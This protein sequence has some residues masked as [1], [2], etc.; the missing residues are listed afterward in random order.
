MDVITEF[1]LVKGTLGVV[2]AAL[3]DGAAEL[4]GLEGD[5]VAGEDAADTGEVD[6]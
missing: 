3:E 4:G 5:A 6:P 1:G 2:K